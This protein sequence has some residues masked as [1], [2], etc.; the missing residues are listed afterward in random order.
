M[1]FWRRI[2]PEL[3]ELTVK[4]NDLKDLVVTLRAELTAAV[5]RA[6]ADVD[7]LKA[8]LANGEVI[9]AEDLDALGASLQS[10]IDIAKA[11]DPDP[12]NPATPPLPSPP[13]P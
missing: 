1:S 12:S 13:I 5:A 11:A 10:A 2:I 6:Q 4:F 9:A 3:E 8:K 7:A